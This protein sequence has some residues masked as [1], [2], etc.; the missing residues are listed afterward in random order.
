MSNSIKKILSPLSI[1]IAL[2][3]LFGGPVIFIGLAILLTVI[4]LIFFKNAG[5]F[6]QFLYVFTLFANIFVTSVILGYL[7]S[8]FVIKPL[9]KLN[10][11]IEKLNAG[12]ENIDIAPTGIKDIDEVITTFQNFIQQL[13]QESNLRKDL[14][15]DTSHELKTPIAAM[16]IQLQGVRD[17]VLQ[18][19]E[20]R[21]ELLYTQ[22]ERLNDLVQ[23]LQNYSK[24]RSQSVHVKKET[25][26]LSET[27]NECAATL[28]EKAKQ[29]GVSIQNLVSPDFEVQADKKLMEQ[30]FCNLIDNAIKYSGGYLVSIQADK[31]K[32][33]IEDNGVGI[34]T[35]KL[36]FVFERFYR[37]D[38]SR[39]R[40]TGGLGLG[41]AIVKE[42]VEAHGWNIA[43]KNKD[44]VSG[45]V[46]EI[47]M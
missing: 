46:F 10:T 28:E 2:L 27:I 13:K 30:V 12:D 11:V 22:V 7:A 34:D 5:T 15:S 37:V 47:F 44:K 18:L 4:H 35:A 17:G 19:D 32:I 36:S 20:Q 41:L 23:N 39:N 29:K 38:D 26:K 6:I 40:E 1:R 25:I 8:R 33:T 16:M 43:V 45:L 14:I 42:I 24:I 3:I 31:D 9:R 21:I